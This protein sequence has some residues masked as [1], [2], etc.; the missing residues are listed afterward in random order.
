MFQQTS[1]PHTLDGSKYLSLIHEQTEGRILGAL[2][3][4]PDHPVTYT[5]LE[6]THVPRVSARILTHFLQSQWWGIKFGIAPY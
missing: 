1:A 3:V 6:H 4:L 2:E 5:G